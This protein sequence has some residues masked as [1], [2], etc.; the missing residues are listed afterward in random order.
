MTRSVPEWIGKTADTAIPT[1]VRASSLRLVPRSQDKDRRC[2]EGKDLRAARQARRY[3][4]AC[5]PADTGEQKHAVESQDRRRMGA[6]M[7]KVSDADALTAVLAWERCNE[8]ADRSKDELVR[9]GWLSDAEAAWATMQRWLA[10]D[11]SPK[12]RTEQRGRR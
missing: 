11:K 2:R 12:A 3:P 7:K 1:R 6:A 8:M 10:Q 4:Q 9:N 5:E